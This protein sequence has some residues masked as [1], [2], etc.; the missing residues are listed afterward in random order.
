ML[1]RCSISTSPSPLLFKLPTTNTIAAATHH[2][3]CRS[4]LSSFS[5]WSAL[6]SGPVAMPPPRSLRSATLGKSSRY[7]ARSRGGI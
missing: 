7:S 2:R 1:M 6:P 5:R 3:H 4:I